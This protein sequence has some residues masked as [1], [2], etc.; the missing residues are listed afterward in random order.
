MTHRSK[1]PFGRYAHASV[2]V[3][4]KLYIFGGHRIQSPSFFMNDLQYLDMAAHIKGKIFL[5]FIL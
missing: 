4:E 5:K 2:L 3:G 1:L